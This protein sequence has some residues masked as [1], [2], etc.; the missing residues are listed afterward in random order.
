MDLLAPFS[1]INNHKGS[2]AMEKYIAD[3]NKKE[4]PSDL[5]G[6]PVWWRLLDIARTFF[7]QK[8]GL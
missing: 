1:Y 7:E 2:G 3:A 4:N 6:V 5:E 8:N